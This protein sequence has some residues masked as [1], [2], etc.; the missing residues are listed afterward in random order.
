MEVGRP[1]HLFYIVDGQYFNSL[2]IVEFNKF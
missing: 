1:L 2:V